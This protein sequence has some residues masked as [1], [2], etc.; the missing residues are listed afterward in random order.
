M[1]A[2]GT[3]RWYQ[4]NVPKREIQEAARPAGV[5]EVVSAATSSIRSE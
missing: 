5:G 4:V 1:A 3:T 2:A